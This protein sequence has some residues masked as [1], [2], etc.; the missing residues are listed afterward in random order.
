MLALVLLHSTGCLAKLFAEAVEAIEPGPV[1]GVRATGADKIQEILYG[2]IPAAVL[3]LWIFYSL[4]RFESNVRSA[5]GGGVMVGAGGIGVL[6]RESIR[7]FDFPATCAI[8]LIIIVTVTVIDALSQI[9][10]KRF[11]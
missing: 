7:G 10:R 2:V 8:M 11:I 3:P 6:L 9:L 5:D 4:Y 1:E